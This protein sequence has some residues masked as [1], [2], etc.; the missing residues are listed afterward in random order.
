MFILALFILAY[1]YHRTDAHDVGHDTYP[2]TLAAIAQRAR[3]LASLQL[4]RDGDR[5]FGRYV[6][7]A[8][9]ERNQTIDGRRGRFPS[10]RPAACS[11][12]RG[13]TGK[14]DRFD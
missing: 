12:C 9:K 10:S 6:A 13:E 4:P 5:T 1:Q 7:S 8:R 14:N 2:Q 11:A 3:E